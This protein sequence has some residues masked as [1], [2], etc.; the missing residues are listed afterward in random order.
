MGKLP[1][2]AENAR[3]I[4]IIER[5]SHGWRASYRMRVPSDIFFQRGEF[6]IFSTEL[7]ATKWLHA[8]AADRGFSSIEIRR[9]P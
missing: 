9:Q 3:F 6:E 5:C 1:S 4:G 2:A 8:Q 7:E